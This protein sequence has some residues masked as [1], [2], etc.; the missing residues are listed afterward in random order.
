MNKSVNIC[1]CDNCQ[2]VFNG[3][4]GAFTCPECGSDDLTT[5][6]SIHDIFTPWNGASEADNEEAAA[7]LYRDLQNG[8]VIT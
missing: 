6:L 1:Q 3:L 7:E 4:I 5:D 2:A 8:K